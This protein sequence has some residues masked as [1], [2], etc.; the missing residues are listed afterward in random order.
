MNRGLPEMQLLVLSFQ[1]HITSFV[2]LS[3]TS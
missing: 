1:T 3:L 2:S